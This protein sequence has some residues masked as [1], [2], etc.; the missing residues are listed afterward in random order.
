MCLLV[1]LCCSVVTSTPNVTSESV[2]GLG[3]ESPVKDWLVYSHI[4]K[5][6]KGP[7]NGY[8][9]MTGDWE[10][11]PTPYFLCPLIWVTSPFLLTPTSLPVSIAKYYSMLHNFFPIFPTSHHPV[12]PISALT[13][14]PLSMHFPQ[15][16]LLGP[17]SRNSR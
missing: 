11:V 15:P 9:C 17:V 7:Y 5:V 10:G 6:E 1:L 3:G 16:S 2:E 4:T 14:F 13:L 8:I 12:I